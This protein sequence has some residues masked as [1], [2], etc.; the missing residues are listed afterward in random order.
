MGTTISCRAHA[1]EGCQD[2]TLEADVYA[3]DS[4]T[5]DGTWNGQTVICDVCLPII[6]PFANDNDRP[7]CERAIEHY[8]SNRD[9]LEAHANPVELVEEA[10]SQLGSASPGSPRHRSVVACLSMAEAE[11]ARRAGR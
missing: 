3:P 7:L 10:R 6:E 5:D 2:G 4:M 9:W 11:V 1:T 8:W